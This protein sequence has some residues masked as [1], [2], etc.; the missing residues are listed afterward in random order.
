MNVF[1]YE[2]RFHLRKGGTT[3]AVTSVT[4]RTISV[5]FMLKSGPGASCLNGWKH[6]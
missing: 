3:F 2:N 1:E 4:I 5:L 6:A